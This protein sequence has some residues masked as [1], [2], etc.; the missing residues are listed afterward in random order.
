MLLANESLPQR[1]ESLSP[2]GES[3]SECL[4]IKVGAR[5]GIKIGFNQNKYFLQ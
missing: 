5:F 4:F 2:S 3:P 1:M